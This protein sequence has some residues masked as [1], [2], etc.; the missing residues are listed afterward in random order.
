M[1]KP[2]FSIIT[3]C[4]NSEKT[5][6]QSIQSLMNQSFKDF[7]YII[8][9]GGSDDSTLD[10]INKYRDRITTVVSEKDN[11]IYDAMNKGITLAKG[12]IIG[13]LNSDDWYEPDTLEII[14]EEYLKS[15]KK[16]LFHG[17]SKLIENEKEGRIFSDHHDVLPTHCIQHPTCFVPKRIYDEYGL[18]NT[19]YKVAGDYDFLLRLYL[20]GVD[21]KRIERVLVNFRTD[22]ISEGQFS[23]YE[24]LAIQYK[25]NLF[26]RGKYTLKLMKQVVFHL[27]Q[28]IVIRNYQRFVLGR[29]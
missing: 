5:I 19:T 4:Y 27:Y 10:I 14:S 21:F 1:S 13:L 8:I 15:D 12:E 29:K 2:L 28:K 6:E 18:F 17:L 26:G 20:S 9:D 11:G 22:G 24:D 23:K 25:N 7:E 3:V 16:T